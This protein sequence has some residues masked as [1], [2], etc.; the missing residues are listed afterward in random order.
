LGVPNIFS[1]IV[2]IACLEF[3]VRG[4]INSDKWP[5]DLI[6]CAAIGCALREAMRIIIS[7][8]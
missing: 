1:R 4:Q 3:T 8:A 6:A 5:L 2:V 7:G